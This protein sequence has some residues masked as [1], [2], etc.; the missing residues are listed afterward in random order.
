MQFVCWSPALVL[1]LCTNTHLIVA[2]PSKLK[3]LIFNKLDWILKLCQV[4]L[5][6]HFSEMF[7]LSS[8]PPSHSYIFRL[9]CTR[10]GQW[11]IGYVT[12]DGNILQTIPHNKPL[13]QALI[14]GYREGL[15]VTYHTVALVQLPP[16]LYIDPLPTPLPPPQC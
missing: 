1:I 6:E 11:A 12:S 5:A 3:G 15:Y 10:L 2:A 14:D 7:V 13:F 4:F 8:L 16:C 9:S